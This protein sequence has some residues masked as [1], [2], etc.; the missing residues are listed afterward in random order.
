M[1]EWVFWYIVSGTTEWGR[2]QHLTTRMLRFLPYYRDRKE[3]NFHP[4]KI[5]SLFNVTA[6]FPFAMPHHFSRFAVLFLCG[7]VPG[8]WWAQ[9]SW[10]C[11]CQPW[12]QEHMGQSHQMW[13]LVTDVNFPLGKGAKHPSL[14]HVVCRGLMP[15]CLSTGDLTLL[16][17][18]TWGQTGSAV[19]Y[20]QETDLKTLC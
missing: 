13:K 12:G 15:S 20:R 2:F 6:F 19:A 14:N 9:H 17:T 5:F 1:S 7:G 8:P 10:S 4:P 3:S 11:M 16:L 18:E